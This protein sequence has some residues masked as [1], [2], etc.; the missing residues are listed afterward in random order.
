MD[1][2]FRGESSV[3]L[4]LIIKNRQ[5]RNGQEEE[6]VV[7]NLSAPDEEAGVEGKECN[8]STYFPCQMLSSQE[9]SESETGE[10]DKDDDNCTGDDFSPL[11]PQ[12]LEETQD[13][14]TTKGKKT[15][16]K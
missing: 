1:K 14:E 9:V 15:C 3:S 8:L 13:K 12:E 2:G 16:V 5:Q 11:F 7:L 6:V 4:S 10:D